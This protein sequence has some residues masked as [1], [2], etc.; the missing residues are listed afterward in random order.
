MPYDYRIFADRNLLLITGSGLVTSED[1]HRVVTGFQRDPAW[2]PTM[3]MLVDWRR[4][5]ELSIDPDEVAKLAAE[6]LAP[7]QME[8]GTPLGPRAAVVLSGHEH[9]EVPMLYY[10][11]LRKSGL[12]AKIFFGMEEAAEWLGVDLGALGDEPPPPGE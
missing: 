9:V 5:S 8:L 4:V 11:Q 1:I 3:M 12:K 6:A 10:G 2:R 7:E